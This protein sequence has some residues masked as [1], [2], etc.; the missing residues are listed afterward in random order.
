[1]AKDQKLHKLLISQ[2][3]IEIFKH[4]IGNMHA[5]LSP[6]S[7]NHFS[8]RS[9]TLIKSIFLVSVCMFMFRSF[10]SSKYYVYEIFIAYLIFFER[11]KLE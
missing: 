6:H 1:M 7:F 2:N 10:I 5:E 4:R 11:E 3:R 8:Q 9:V